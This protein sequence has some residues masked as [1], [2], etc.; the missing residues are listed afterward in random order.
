MRTCRPFAF[1]KRFSSE[2]PEHLALAIAAHPAHIQSKGKSQ[3]YSP[4][5]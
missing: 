4:T 1:V 3:T 2:L 5:N